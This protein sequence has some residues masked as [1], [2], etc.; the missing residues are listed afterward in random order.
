MNEEILA[1]LYFLGIGVGVFL[2]CRYV[3]FPG[4]KFLAKKTTT[5]LDDILL[6][7]KFLNRFSLV[8]VF[9]SLKVYMETSVG[10]PYF[11]SF[12]DR[13]INILLA[14][15]IGLSISEFLTLINKISCTGKRKFFE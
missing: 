7:K 14:I 1:I 2:L 10:L 12:S 9:S 11:D 8:I 3:F 4:I 15:F 6:D 13:I 5:I